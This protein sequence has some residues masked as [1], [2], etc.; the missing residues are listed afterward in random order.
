MGLKRSYRDRITYRSPNS[1]MWFG[2]ILLCCATAPGQETTTQ[3]DTSTESLTAT[4]DDLLPYASPQAA[5]PSTGT[6]TV[7]E[8]SESKWHIYGL[9]YI[10]LPGVHG[11]AGGSRL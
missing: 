10:W 9:T 6:Q 3:V 4:S 11:S 8:T 5:A 2:I 1:V 7:D